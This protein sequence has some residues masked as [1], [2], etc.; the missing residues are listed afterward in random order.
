MQRPQR[1]VQAGHCLAP[2]QLG[3]HTHAR[4]KTLM[5]LEL[6]P[7]LLLR[8]AVLL[9]PLGLLRLLLPRLLPPV[10]PIVPLPLE[11]R[12]LPKRGR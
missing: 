12:V 11:Q 3:V 7:R 5:A 9:L 1:D 10:R 8:M 4:R 2:Q 6:L